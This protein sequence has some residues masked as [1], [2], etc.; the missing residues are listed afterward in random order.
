MKS[1]YLRPY[2]DQGWG[3]YQLR[4]KFLLPKSD[5][6]LRKLFYS[7]FVVSDQSCSGN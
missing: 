3:V 1:T 4:A 7:F 2:V 6:T 5:M